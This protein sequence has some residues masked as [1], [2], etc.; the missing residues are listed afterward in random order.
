MKRNILLS[1]ELANEALGDKLRE[2]S[3]AF[4]IQIKH[5]YVS[6][7][8]K[9]KHLTKKHIKILF[10][11]GDAK[12]TRVLKN[13]VGFGYIRI[14][15]GLIIANSLRSNKDLVY[16]IEVKDS[17]LLNK[18]AVKIIR[19]AVAV[20][21]IGILTFYHDLKQRQ[22]NPKSVNDYKRAC[23]KMRGKGE[24]FST[25]VSNS[26]MAEILN[27]KL[28]KARQTMQEITNAGV[29]TKK[30]QY[31]PFI[32]KGHFTMGHWRH[33]A[34]EGIFLKR[35]NGILQE[36]LSNLYLLNKTELIRGYYSY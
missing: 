7:A 14:E 8:L 1:V 10:K 23:K 26:R 35:K 5:T 17:T 19:H 28:W 36:Q 11:I 33:F 24:A 9:G 21:H 25:G 32:V 13:G 2:E 18:D 22:T 6:S 4:A 16:K 12:L 31:R 15:D 3:L 20:R 29:F 34:S 27:C 30:E